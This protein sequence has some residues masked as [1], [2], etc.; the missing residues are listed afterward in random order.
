MYA[1]ILEN[2]PLSTEN[3]LIEITTYK[4]YVFAHFGSHRRKYHN[5]R[6]QQ[7]L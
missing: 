3:K 1:H 2:K 6:D 5:T 7:H 4:I